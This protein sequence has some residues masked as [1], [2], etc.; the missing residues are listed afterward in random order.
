MD[1]KLQGQ[2]SYFRWEIRNHVSAYGVSGLYRNVR[3][4]FQAREAVI[5]Q[6]LGG[7]DA[8]DGESVQHTASKTC[9]TRLLTPKQLCAHFYG[10][11]HAAHIEAALS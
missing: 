10:L 3:T 6:A 8:A 9:C 4:F 5:G 2:D 11:H 7:L 1:A